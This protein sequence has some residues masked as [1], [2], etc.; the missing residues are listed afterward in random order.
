MRRDGR[1]GEGR[2][3]ERVF[4]GETAGRDGF[5]ADEGAGFGRRRGGGRNRTVGGGAGR[6]CDG[7]GELRALFRE[8]GRSGSGRGGSGEIGVDRGRL[9]H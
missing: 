6:R 4:R 7:E 9:A 8:R 3:G 5:S 1:N 2:E